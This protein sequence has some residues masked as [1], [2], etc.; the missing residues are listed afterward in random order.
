[1]H[2]IV[3]ASKI[4]QRGSRVLNG[5]IETRLS[6][7]FG[8]LNVADG[9][10][11]IVER[12]GA[13]AGSIVSPIG[14][15]S[16]IPVA[17]A[18]GTFCGGFR[19][20]AP[21]E[22]TGP[23]CAGDL[24][25]PDELRERRAD[26]QG[27][28]AGAECACA[29]TGETI[30]IMMLY[31][32]QARVAAG[33]V[34]AIEAIAEASIEFTNLAYVN[35]AIAPLQLRIVHMQEVTYDETVAQNVEHLIRLSTNGDGIL[36]EVHSLRDQYHADLV[37]LLIDN[38]NGG[39]GWRNV[40]DPGSG[41]SVCGWYSTTFGYVMAHETGHN[42]GCAHD[43]PNHFEFPNEFR[44]GYGQTFDVSG[45]PYAT[46][47]SYVGEGSARYSNPSV[48]YLGVP[49]GVALNQPL[50][51]NNA[52][53]IENARRSIA[54]FRAS[55]GAVDCNGNGTA[56]ATDIAGGF[57]A[58]E[59]ENC[60][61]D[62]CEFVL[63]V[64]V[65]SAANGDGR[66]W[67]TAKRSIQEALLVAS[68]PCSHVKQ[69]WVKAGTYSPDEGSGD[70]NAAYW[71]VPGVSLLGGFA[72]DET[73][74]DQRDIAANPTYLSG[75][76]GVPDEPSDN[77]HTILVAIDVLRPV[78]LDGF[79][80]RAARNTS[81]AGGLYASNSR[82]TLRNCE[83]SDNVADGG[84]GLAVYNCPQITLENCTLT[85]NSAVG[86]GGA[87][88][89]SASGLVIRD[90]F[91]FENDADDGA[92]M[93][94]FG[95]AG[96][97]TID[98][99]QF[100][101]NTAEDYAG[102]AALFDGA[103]TIRDSIFFENVANAHEAGGIWAYGLS[104]LIIE[105][106]AFIGHN[107]TGYG[108]ALGLNTVQPAIR[109]CRFISNRALDGAAISAA[110]SGNML[111]EACEFRSNQA[112]NRGGAFDL[113]GG[114]PIIRNSVFS[115]NRALTGEAGAIHFNSGAASAIRNCTF[116]N[117]TAATNGGGVSSW[118]TTPVIANSIF[119]QN[120]DSGGMDESGQIHHYFGAITIH[121]SS[122]QGWTGG[123][124]GVGNNGS[125]PLLVDP[126]QTD[127]RLSANSPCIDAGENAEAGSGVTTDYAGN[128]RFVDA[129]TVP[130]TGAGTPPLVDRGALEYQPPLLR[131]D[132]NCDGLVNNFDIDPFVLALTDAD[133]YAVL[134]PSCDIAAADINVDG[135]VNNFD[136]DPFV[137][138]LTTGG[139][140]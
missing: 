13:V 116:Y 14:A 6:G 109:N 41:F 132:M 11:V 92:G 113:F 103:V 93:M 9:Q 45:T 25:L 12:N 63:Y 82:V 38:L 53:M 129:P 96:A 78:V 31:D 35:S 99:C 79:T 118:N 64:D 17:D 94:F 50:P 110:F 126:A 29:D 85:L 128:P 133:G 107:A 117:N 67:T 37:T 34:A 65:D 136:I 71:L 27:G 122:V 58:D 40:F 83:I 140:P 100:T 134:Y 76:I 39:L 33:G 124:G 10:F 22:N 2:G 125:N 32:T 7:C 5:A 114:T 90:S 130:D 98:H 36:D 84:G 81:V 26:E 15:R 43:R 69:I 105:G 55:G 106:T 75:D 61:P 44:Y 72:G 123:L 137:L 16:I 19:I 56:D 87:L 59:N 135:L 54:N 70:S 97:L 119:W 60:V 8:G 18:N 91:V 57:S 30:D 111:V 86:G 108:G 88:L 95:A 49:T 42:L 131:A 102:A 21:R 1:M 74:P 20:A 23:I 104:Q 68:V 80:V 77:A 112:I 115:G 4:N 24:P 28:A 127:F 101:G 3:R 62:E 51:T 121:Y 46:I 89:S 47:M 139:C 138:C 48:T 66:S 52:L 73:S 120:A